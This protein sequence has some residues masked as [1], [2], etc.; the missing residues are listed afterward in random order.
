MLLV[1][2]ETLLAIAKHSKVPANT[3]ALT[4]ADVWKG[5]VRAVAAAVVG[6]VHAERRALRSRVVRERA[7]VG[8]VRAGAL[9]EGPADRDLGRVVLVHAGEAAVARACVSGQGGSCW[10]ES[11]VRDSATGR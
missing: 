6:E 9:Q 1:A 7:G 10:R 5:A 4:D 2:V 3:F 11:Y 8:G